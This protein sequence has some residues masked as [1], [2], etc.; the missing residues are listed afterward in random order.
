[1]RALSDVGNN[2]FPPYDDYYF[3][4][5]HTWAK[6]GVHALEISK[7]MRAQ[8]NL[9]DN[10]YMEST[11]RWLLE[12]YADLETKRIRH[13][14]QIQKSNAEFHTDKPKPE[15]LIFLWIR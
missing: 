1:M 12:H 11:T 2:D 6:L 5:Q 4:R 9:K 15:A 7:K 8:V 3:A 14:E 13:D 10:P